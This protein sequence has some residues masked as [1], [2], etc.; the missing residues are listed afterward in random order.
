MLDRLVMEYVAIHRSR[1]WGL[2]FCVDGEV[3][4]E[5]IMRGFRLRC[6]RI[7]RCFPRGQR[8]EMSFLVGRGGVYMRLD[9][10]A[11]QLE[12]GSEAQVDTEE[13]GLGRQLIWLTSCMGRD[14][15]RDQ[16]ASVLPRAY[17]GLSREK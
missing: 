5:V 3:G 14:S 4:G 8:C 17:R 6:R 11:K 13:R 15:W 10:L 9:S 16:E 2:M 7:G 1:V 12:R